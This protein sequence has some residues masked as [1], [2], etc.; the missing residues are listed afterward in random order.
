MPLLESWD[1]KVVFNVDQNEAFATQVFDAYFRTPDAT[2]KTYDAFPDFFLIKP[3]VLDSMRLSLHSQE[4]QSLLACKTQALA[5]DGYIGVTKYFD[6]EF[7][8]H[9]IKFSPYPFKLGDDANEN[10]AEFYTLFS[11]FI[12]HTHEHTTIYGDLSTPSDADQDVTSLLRDIGDR[13]AQIN[14]KLMRYPESMLLSYDIS[15]PTSEVGKL[16]STLASNDEDGH[17]LF[18]EYLRYAMRRKAG[19]GRKWRASIPAVGTHQNAEESVQAGGDTLV[20]S[21]DSRALFDRIEMAK[22]R[23]L[24]LSKLSDEAHNQAIQA[25]EEKVR[26]EALAVVAARKQISDAKAA[27]RAALERL[28]K[29]RL[30]RVAEESR[31]SALEQQQLIHERAAS[32]ALAE[33]LERAELGNANNTNFEDERH[34]SVSTHQHDVERPLIT[35]DFKSIPGTK[36]KNDNVEINTSTYD[37]FAYEEE[38]SVQRP[39]PVAPTRGVTESGPSSEGR[40]TVR[41]GSR[42]LKHT[43]IV[44]SVIALVFLSLGLIGGRFLFNPPQPSALLVKAKP[45]SYPAEIASAVLPTSGV[46]AAT[47]QDEKAVGGEILSPI[48]LKMSDHLTL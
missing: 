33:R 26:L 25:E 40:A 9:W 8:Y 41:I 18:M 34:F 11:R 48:P 19:L 13:A 32:R 37:P 21:A 39:D 28:E 29:I 14:D 47:S 23:S 46:N 42:R 35:L 38:L 12:L 7:A 3:Q 22:L 17:R 16:M 2:G 44:Q 4:E 15:W 31:I 43:A 1:S 10:Q 36:V 5:R 24:N 27:S 6:E 20:V 45:I 30:A